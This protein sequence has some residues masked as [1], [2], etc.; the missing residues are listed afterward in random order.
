MGKISLYGILLVAAVAVGVA[1]S[2]KPWQVYVEQRAQTD[3]S[4]AEMNQIEKRRLELID[5]KTRYESSAGRE[6]LARNK[7]YLRPGEK[8]IGGEALNEKSPD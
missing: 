4:V 7:G 5:K 6:E 2:I 8:L 3:K 1:Y